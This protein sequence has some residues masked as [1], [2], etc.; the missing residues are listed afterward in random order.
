MVDLGT[1][2]AAVLGTPKAARWAVVLDQLCTALITAGFS[3]ANGHT[4]DFSTLLVRWGRWVMRNE[5]KKCVP[6]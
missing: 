5:T 6:P 3:E 1:K 2:N 4:S